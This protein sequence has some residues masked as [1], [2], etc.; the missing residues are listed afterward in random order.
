MRPRAETAAPPPRVTADDLEFMRESSAAALMAP[1]WHSHLIVWIVFAFL[2]IALAWASLAHIDE[3]A[4]GEGEVLPSSRVQVAQNLEGGI[5]AEIPVKPG[6]RVEKGQIVM[7]LD[8]TRFASSFNEGA[9]KDLA[10]L[11]R[12]ARLEAESQGRLFETPMELARDNPG[13]VAQ[14]QALHASRRRELEANLAIL[15]EQAQQREQQ[16]AE[17]RA[18]ELQLEESYSLAARELA[19]TRALAEGGAV[20]EVELLRLERI[21]NDLEGEL[22]GTRLTLPRLAAARR[23]VEE[24]SRGYLAQHRADASRL[25]SEARAEQAAL[26]AA[27]VGLADRVSRTDVRAPMSGVVKQV[28][29]ST[30]GG[31]I[32]PGMDVLEIVPEEDQLVIEARVRPAD[33]AFLHVGQQATVKLSAFD[34]SIYGGFSGTVEH[35]SADTVTREQADRRV[36]SY[37]TIHVRTHTD[38]LSNWEGPV[39]ILPGMEATVDIRTGRRTVMEYLLKPIIKT[40]ARALRER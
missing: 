14:E 24:K 4:T 11:A 6:D 5:V 8:A 22:E 30:I 33:I 26:S 28:M 1:A 9:A 29:V 21:A 18:R 40:Q 23:E 10:L 16:F 36:L 19:L 2:V 7:R 25:L 34:F 31:V 17:Q 27:N 35:I 12:I 3:I 38:R 32:Q 39:S 13:L 37:Y 15:R 20:S